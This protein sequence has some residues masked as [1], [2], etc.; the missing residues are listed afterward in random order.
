VDFFISPLG[1]FK[2]SE[3]KLDV[4]IKASDERNKMDFVQACKIIRSDIFQ[5]EEQLPVDIEI[6]LSL[7]GE[8]I[9]KKRYLVVNSVTLMTHA[10][11]LEMVSKMCKKLVDS[12]RFVAVIK[13]DSCIQIFL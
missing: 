11:Q 12:P 2:I 9:E 7:L 13:D 5:S 3:E 10:R 6:Y 8:F 4:L 1:K